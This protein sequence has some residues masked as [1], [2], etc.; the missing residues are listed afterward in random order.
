[1][2]PDAAMSVLAGGLAGF[3]TARILVAV[4]TKAPPARLMRTNING[5]QVPVVL[6]GPLALGSLT[7]MALVAMT[8]AV[9]WGP[10]RAGSVAA[11]IALLIVVLTLAGGLDDRRGNEPDKGFRGHL[12]AARGGRLTGGLVKLVAGG[13]A[14]LAAGALVDGGVMVMVVGAAVALG[15]NLVNLTDRAPGRAGKVW[16]LV[17]VPLM[18]W[19]DPGWAVAAAPLAGALFG[20]LGADLGER[21]MLGDA[22]ANPLG[23]VLG[24]GLAVSLPAAGVLVAVVILL[25]G[26]L[27]SEKW[28]FSRAIDRTP[29]LK[30]VDRLGRK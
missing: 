8:G 25:A 15:A 27:A 10:G 6:G 20:C 7:G 18:V 17:A 9:G 30:A 22:G 24:L 11:G 3:A 13:L 5:Q 29:W 26:N 19:G 21:G 16:L 4:R 14:G 1:M 23:A 28:S 2:T 12:R